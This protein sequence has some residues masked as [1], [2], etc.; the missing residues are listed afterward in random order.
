MHKGHHGHHHHDGRR[1]GED[2]GL[3]RLLALL[4][5]WVDHSDSHVEGYREWAG[6]AGAAGEEE[7]A[8][9]V[10]L[11][12]E[13]SQAARDHLKRAK[14]VLAAKLLLKKE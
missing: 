8:R 2:D 13:S 5:H 1:S 11:A 4:D 12:I 10:H 7:V 3:R 14:A 9:E 6:K